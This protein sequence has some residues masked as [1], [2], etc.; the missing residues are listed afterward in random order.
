MSGHK[1]V[2]HRRGDRSYFATCTCRAGSDASLTRQEAEDWIIAHAQ[3]VERARAA[4]GRGRGSLRTDMEHARAMLED[5]NTP[6]ADKPAWQVIYDGARQRL[7]LDH[8]PGEQG[9]LW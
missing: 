8:L 2:L 4:L 1:T 5:P 9:D 3:Q 6:A 7:G